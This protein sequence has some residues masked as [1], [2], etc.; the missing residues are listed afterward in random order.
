MAIT[1]GARSSSTPAV[2][3]TKKRSRVKYSRSE[4]L[5]QRAT[6][7][8]TIPVLTMKNAQAL[9]STAGSC[10]AVNGWLV[11]M[12][13]VSVS[14]RSVST[15]AI[16]DS[17]Y[18]AALKLMRQIGLRDMTSWISDATLWA[19]IAGP[20]PPASRS[21]MA[22]DVDSVISSSFP[23]RGIFTGRVSVRIT[24]ELS[25]MKFVGCTTMKLRFHR[26]TAPITA[27]TEMKAQYVWELSR[28]I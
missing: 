4:T 18:C 16:I 20:S 8:P 22:N 6:A 27:N 15:A 11:P 13:E 5:C 7:V 21:A 12:R 1:M 24:A 17:A 26:R 19:R 25:R 23:R 10:P 3:I 14:S 9:A 2:V 28:G